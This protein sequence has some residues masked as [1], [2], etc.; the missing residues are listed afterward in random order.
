MRDAD[1]EGYEYEAA[2]LTARLLLRPERDGDR[3]ALAALAGGR[4]GPAY[5]DPPE[6]SPGGEAF[7]VVERDGCAAAGVCGY[8]PMPERPALVEVATW[9]AEPFCGRGLATEATQAVID[10][11]FALGAATVLWCAVRVSDARARRVIEKCGF[12]YRGTGMGRSLTAVGAVPVER[13]ILERKSWVSLKSW[14]AGIRTD[15][16]DAPE[17]DAA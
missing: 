14:G 11:A 8:G 6:R 12:Q 2:I 1:Q 17:T 10:R 13:F 5:F 9:I 4:T 7:V 15:R 3:A 16:P